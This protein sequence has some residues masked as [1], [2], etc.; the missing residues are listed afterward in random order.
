LNQFDKSKG[1]TDWTLNFGD[2]QLDSLLR[3]MPDVKR[4]QAT[5]LLKLNDSPMLWFYIQRQDSGRVRKTEAE[6]CEDFLDSTFEKF[7]TD[8]Q[9]Y[10]FEDGNYVLST[11]KMPFPLPSIPADS[12]SALVFN[13]Y[14]PSKPLR[15]TLDR[16]GIEPDFEIVNRLRTNLSTLA[17]PFLMCKRGP[18]AIEG[19]K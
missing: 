14:D 4:W 3:D 10:I 7:T 17:H 15:E 8:T 6:V 13:S 9:A 1:S 19:A 2:K 12:L 5:N 18:A 16:L 11:E